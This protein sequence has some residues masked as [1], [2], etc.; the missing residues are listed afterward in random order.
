MATRVLAFAFALVGTLFAGARLLGEPQGGRPAPPPSVRLY[1]LDGGVLESDPGRYKLTKEDVGTTQLSV[2]AYLIAHPKGV[3]MWD[4]G[5]ITDADWSPTGKP[6][7]QKLT[8]P[9]GQ[10]RQVTIANGL[11]PQLKAAGYTPADVTHLALS[12]YHWDHTANA[13]VFARATWLVR[14]LEREAMFPEK[15]LGTARPM[16]YSA[17]KTSRTTTVKDDEHDV[18]GDG[19]VILKSAPGHTPGHQV[20]YVKL[21]RTGGVLLSGDLYHYQAERRLDR[22]PTFEFDVEQT[23]GARRSVEAFLKKTGAQLWIQH[24]LDAHTKLKKAPSYYD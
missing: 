15:P 13:N 11:L 23:R 1:V 24:D 16:T 9:D 12:H 3:L 7:V 4:T 17:L 2:A 10:G 5:A 14:P 6:S 22:Y 8:L 18:F 19:T 21:A 20:L